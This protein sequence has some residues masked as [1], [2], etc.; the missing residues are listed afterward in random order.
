MRVV[1]Q[2]VRTAS[3]AVE[4]AVCGQIGA[5]LLVLA[6]FEADDGAADLD[7]MAGKIVRLRLF[8]DDS[9]VMNRSV[10]EAGGAILAVSQF[11]LYASVKKGNRPSWSRAARGDVSQPLFDQFVARLTA[12]MGKPVATGIF[13]A[14]MAVSLV[15]DGPVTLTIDSKNPE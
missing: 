3:V 11:T 2:R 5:G 13:G 8:A 9:G 12:L 7:W 15:N 4:G 1:I 14:D 6:G 10:L